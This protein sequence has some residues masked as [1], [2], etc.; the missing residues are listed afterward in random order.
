MTAS[1]GAGFF[2]LVGSFSL[3]LMV[4]G[5][6]VFAFVAGAVWLHVLKAKKELLARARAT[7]QPRR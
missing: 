7:R 3:L 2:A 1:T 6:V 5:T 4:C